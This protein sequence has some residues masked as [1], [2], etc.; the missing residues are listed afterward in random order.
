[1]IAA[2]VVISLYKNTLFWAKRRFPIF[3]SPFKFALPPTVTESTTVNV[4]FIDISSSK[5][6]ALPGPVGPVI[7]IPWG[8]VT[9]WEP[10]GPV[11]PNAPAIPEGPVGPVGPVAP[12][13]EPLINDITCIYNLY[14]LYFQFDPIVNYS[15]DF[16]AKFVFF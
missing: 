15:L 14:T 10:V 3:T 7:P 11:A 8:P 5:F 1:M 16:S 4:L 13:S 6:V 2:E 12:V 9:P